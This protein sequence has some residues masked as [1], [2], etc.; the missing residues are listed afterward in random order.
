VTRLLDPPRPIEV[1][2]AGEDERP[3]R[4]RGQGPLTGPV[5][6]VQGWITEVDW[7]SQPISREYWRVLLRGRLL[8]E[9]FRDRTDGAWYL[10]RVYD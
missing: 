7:W 1:E 4:I 6:T 8:C 2:T 3:R 9:I 5:R 10:E